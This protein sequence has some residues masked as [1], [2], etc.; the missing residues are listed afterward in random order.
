M[1][2]LP[3][4][5]PGIKTHAKSHNQVITR[6][7]RHCSTDHLSQIKSL[8]RNDIPGRCQDNTNTH[9]PSIKE[10][11][12]AWNVHILKV[13]YFKALMT[14]KRLLQAWMQK[15]I[16]DLSPTEESKLKIIKIWGAATK[17]AVQTSRILA[18]FL[19]CS[20]SWEALFKQCKF[21]NI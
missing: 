8:V 15:S 5:F 1:L 6:N 17:I 10:K 7:L 13:E 18:I 2:T 21:W 20:N 3:S 11:T 14:R 12:P 9:I 16:K 19:L 4:P